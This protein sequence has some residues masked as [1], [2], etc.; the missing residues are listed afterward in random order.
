[1]A[2]PAWQVGTSRSARLALL[3]WFFAHCQ[4][5]LI[6]VRLSKTTTLNFQKAHF[7]QFLD[8][9]NDRSLPCSHIVGQSLLAW[10]AEII[11]PRIFEQHCVSEFGP[12]TNLFRDQYKI[13][14]LCKTTSCR[15]DI[16]ASQ[17]NVSLL[18]YA[19]YVH[20]LHR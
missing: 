18:K 6:K 5:Q 17:D 10:K 1:M 3:V 7:L 15:D 20:H 19:L 12:N 13:W 9:P 14:H 16:P 11:L 4:V 2:S 8:P